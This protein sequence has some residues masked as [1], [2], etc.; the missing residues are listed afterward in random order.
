MV[1]AGSVIRR[2]YDW[3]GPRQRGQVRHVLNFFASNDWVVAFFPRVLQLWRGLDLGSA[4]HDR[5]D[6]Q[7]APPDLVQQIGFVDGGHSAALVEANWDAIARFALYGRD[8]QVSGDLLVE[9][10]GPLAGIPLWATILAWLAG[11]AILA[12]PVI[13]IASSDLAKWLRTVLLMLYTLLIW[14]VVTVL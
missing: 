7:T 11:L 8:P 14:K 4:G 12:V 1:L 13:G 6:A 2:D 10:H 3:R 9:R 5:F